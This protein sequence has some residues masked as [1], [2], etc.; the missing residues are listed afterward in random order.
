MNWQRVFGVALYV[1]AGTVALIMLGWGAWALVI[2][3]YI[4]GAIVGSA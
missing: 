2:T 1:A 4:A 3:A